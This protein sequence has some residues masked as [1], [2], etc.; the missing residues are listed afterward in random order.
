MFNRSFRENIVFS[1]IILLYFFVIISVIFNKIS[2]K[3][4]Y[5]QI[6]D[7][8]TIYDRN[9]NI[10]CETR[11]VYDYYLYFTDNIH[12]EKKFI[13][14]YFPKF[15]MTNLKKKKF[16]LMGSSLYKIPI[17]LPKNIS[18]KKHFSRY[19]P[20]G[21][22][23]STLL[24]IRRD[25]IVFG[26]ESFTDNENIV[27]SIDITL[28]NIL[29]KALKEGFKQIRCRSIH[30][31]IENENG[32]VLALASFPNFNP[33]DLNQT[34]IDT[35]NKIFQGVY[36]MGSTI[37][38]FA[39]MSGLHH[40]LIKTTDMFPIFKGAKIGDFIISDVNKMNNYASVEEIL[41][42]SSNVGMVQIAEIIY[43]VVPDFYTSLMFHERISHK[44]IKTPRIFFNKKPSFSL[45]KS[46]CFGYGFALCP[47]NLLRAIRC[48]ATG[49][50]IDSSILK[51]NTPH[52]HDTFFIKNKEKVLNIMENMASKC[53]KTPPH[54]KLMWKTGTARQ[55]INGK[56]LKNQVNTYLVAIL[57]I[58]DKKFFIFFMMER[59]ENIPNTAFF[60]V[61]VVAEQFIRMLIESKILENSKNI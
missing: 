59:P 34:P 44:Y 23:T 16:Y 1:S 50:L 35:S 29:H 47:L 51:I 22:I 33:N 41:V 26:L 5:K 3:K 40:N 54:I 25:N 7:L 13:H 32:E 15:S 10:L 58:N 42:K 24:G 12:E 28:Q 4:S 21:S 27:S 6:K 43:R 20:Y 17:S 2:Y 57:Q 37:K 48:V 36:E 19:Y 14:Q 60:N 11:I 61:R 39:V 45:I 9:K 31:I 56:Y 18:V 52:I 30:A 38:I 8:H 49:N 53:I 55:N 46:Y